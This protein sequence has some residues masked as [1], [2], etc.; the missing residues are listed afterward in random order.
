MK[1]SWYRVKAITYNLSDMLKNKVLSFQLYTIVW[2]ESIDIRGT[3]QLAVFI[4]ACDVEFN[5]LK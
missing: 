3:T 4:H 5:N 2:N 1:Y